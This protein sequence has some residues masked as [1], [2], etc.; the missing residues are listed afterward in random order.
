M[1]RA[2]LLGLALPLVLS[3]AV[4]ASEVAPLDVSYDDAGAVA[5]SLSGVTGDAVA[6]KE[7][8][9]NRGLGNCVACHAVT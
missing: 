4:Y 3:T 5:V 6:G 8:M 1:K 2:A 9:T 7:V